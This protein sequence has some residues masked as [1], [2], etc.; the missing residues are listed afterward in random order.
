M[1]WMGA[2]AVLERSQA[3]K[4]NGRRGPISRLTTASAFAG[5]PH[6]DVID[7]G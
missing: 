2:Y 7:A 6:D 4:S 5:G 1:T 3:T